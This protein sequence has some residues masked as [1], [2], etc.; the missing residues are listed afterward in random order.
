MITNHIITG[1]VFGASMS[2]MSWIVGIIGNSILVKTAYYE[3]LSHLNFIKSKAVNDRI[4][5]PYVKWMVKNTFFKFFN[6]GLK[7]NH[8]KTDL[9][10]LRHQMTHAEIGHLIGF[11][12]VTG[13]ALYQSINIS[14]VFGLAMLLPNVLLNLYPS[15]LQQENKRRI[16][17]L[18]QRQ[19]TPRSIH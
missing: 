15:L 6:P 19:K 13:G 11:V 1:L 18:L 3:K 10:A 4:G 7:V 2:I 9:A 8:R 5:L 17:A 16:D 12:F 14:P